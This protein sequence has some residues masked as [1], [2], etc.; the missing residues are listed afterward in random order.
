MTQNTKHRMSTWNEADTPSY[1]VYVNCPENEITRGNHRNGANNWETWMLP[2][3][4]TKLQTVVVIDS[5]Y[6]FIKHG[7]DSPAIP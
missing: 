7:H 4:E 6:T 3:A 1:H 2:C 5:G